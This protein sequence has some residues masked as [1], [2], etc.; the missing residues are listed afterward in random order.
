M[1]TTTISS[2]GHITLPAALLRERQL[3]PGTRLE[4]IATASAIVLVPVSDSW[5]ASLAGSTGG[6]YGEATAYIE[7]ERAEWTPTF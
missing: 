5:S 3:S 1:S 6:V 2:E 7:R 4:I